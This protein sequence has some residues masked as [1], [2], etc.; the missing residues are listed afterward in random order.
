VLRPDG[1]WSLMVVNRDHD[2]PHEVRIAFHDDAAHSDREFSGPIEVITYAKAQYQ[3]HP[4]R[5]SG[6]ADPDDP[7]AF[8]ALDARPGMTYTLAAASLNIIRGRLAK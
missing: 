2:S 1:K 4:A 6:Y 7:P 3:W 5:R 8:K